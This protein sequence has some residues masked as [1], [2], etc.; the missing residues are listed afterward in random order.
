MLLLVMKTEKDAFWMLAFLLENVLVNDCYS[1]NLSE[2]HVEQRVFQDMLAKKC[3][4]LCMLSFVVKKMQDCAHLEDME[5]DVSL[6]ATE[7][8]LCLFSKQFPKDSILQIDAHALKI[9]SGEDDLVSTTLIV[10]YGKSG[11][12]KEVR[13]AGYVIMECNDGWICYKLGW[14]QGI[15]LVFYNTE[16]CCLVLFQQGKQIHGYIIRLG[17]ESDQCVSSGIL[18]MYIKCGDVSGASLAFDSI[19]EP[20]IV[21]W[22]TMISGCVEN[23]EEDRSLGFYHRMMCLNVSP[24]EYSFETLIKTYSCLTALEQG[25]QIHA[26]AL[27]LECTS[28]QFVGTLLLDMYAK[29]GSI[30]ESYMLFKRMNVRNIA[31]WN[32]MVVGFAQHGNVE[33]AL[34]FFKQMRCQDIKPDSITFFGVLSACSHSGLVSEAYGYFNSMHSMY[35]IEPKIEHYSCLVDVLGRAGHV[36]Q[37]KKLIESMPF[38]PSA[39]MHR[40]LLGGCKL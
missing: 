29:C 25:R 3:P 24:D 4:S 34:N 1:P 31:S 40:A 14:S 7:W 12:M 11:R 2:C 6:V 21:T 19:R 13:M 32:A 18:D 10:V 23:G 37:A 15:E 20:D 36:H 22:T 17:F 26:N 39:S 8:F 5:F 27:K 38:Q 35:G 33:E 30:Q 28:D 16:I 9:G